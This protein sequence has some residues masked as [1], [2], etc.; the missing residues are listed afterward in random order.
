[1]EEKNIHSAPTPVTF[2][3]F[4][5]PSYDEWKQ[6]ATDALKGAPFDKKM[7]TPTFEGI[8][9]QPIYTPGDTE[10]LKDCQGF[11][12]EQDYLRGTKSAY[13]KHLWEIAQGCDT[14]CPVEAGKQLAHEIEKGA[15]VIHPVLDYACTHGKDTPLCECR[16]VSIATLGHVKKFFESVDPTKHELHIAAGAPASGIARD[17]S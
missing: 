4:K 6:A 10:A 2:D 13:G 11:P 16:G 14:R 3:E 7:Y 1:M 12:G 17:I 9:L 8:T 5:I 15:T